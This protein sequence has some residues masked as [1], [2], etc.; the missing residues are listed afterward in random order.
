[1][2]PF[3]LL[4][5]VKG[6][7]DEDIRN[8]VLLKEIQMNLEDTIAFAEARETNRQDAKSLGER[9]TR[10]WRC[11]EEGHSGRTQKDIR[12]TSCDAFNT[13]CEKCNKVG[14]FA[15]R[16]NYLII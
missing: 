1:M 6:L 4:A 13:M 9:Q 7:Y 15:T 5:L 11:G 2:E 12:R 14:H 16:C 8:E 10:C 3:L